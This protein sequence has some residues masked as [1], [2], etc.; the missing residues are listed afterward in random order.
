MK[1]ALIP[2]LFLLREDELRRLPEEETRLFLRVC[3]QFSDVLLTLADKLVEDLWT[4]HDFRL[5]SIEHAADL[6]S[7][8][9][10]SGTGRSEQEYT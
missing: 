9:G 6:P 8:Q 3:K 7:H 2:L 10:L 4:I 5:P 1:T